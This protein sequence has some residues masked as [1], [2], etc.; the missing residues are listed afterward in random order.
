[1]F[2]CNH[3]HHGAHYMSLL[4]LHLLKQSIKIHR[5]GLSQV[6]NSATDILQ[7]GPDNIWS[8]TTRLTTPMY[9]N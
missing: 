8:H 7:Q 2:R 1:M 5:F 9:F 3:H 4:K 6:T